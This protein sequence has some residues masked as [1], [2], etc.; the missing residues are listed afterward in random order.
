MERTRSL[1]YIHRKGWN[2]EMGYPLKISE[3]IH[4]LEDIKSKYGDLSVAIYDHEFDLYSFDI[5]YV[6]KNVANAR[7]NAFSHLRYPDGSIFLT[8]MEGPIPE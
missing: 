1:A 3:L 4:D 2:Y 8:F 7:I 6:T 5:A